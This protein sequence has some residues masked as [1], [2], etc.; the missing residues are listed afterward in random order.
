MTTAKTVTEQFRC[1]IEQAGLPTP[2]EVIADGRIHRFPTNHSCDDKAGWYLLFADGIPAGAFGCWRSGV[3]ETWSAASGNTMT[4]EESAS[5]RQRLDHIR[6][7]RDEEQG[8]RHR[9]AAVEAGTIWNSAEPATPAHPYLQRKHVRPH[10]LR[11]HQDR[12]MVPVRD[13]NG[14]L[15]SLQLI[16]GEGEK[17]F[18]TGG[19][20]ADCCY[21]IGE[22]PT[23]F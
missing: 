20:T 19:R 12:L 16:D 13:V 7:L 10:G 4:E 14:T 22:T 5:H 17:R 15:H 8:R 3:H 23:V 11:I 2:I 1:A 18:L 21:V 6:Q 9:E